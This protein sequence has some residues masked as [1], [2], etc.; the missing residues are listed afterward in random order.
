MWK[1]IALGT[2]VRL[3]FNVVLGKLGAVSVP[4]GLGGI[5]LICCILDAR[6]V[7]AESSLLA[8]SLQMIL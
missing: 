1:V 8:A 2:A 7:E 6:A 4:I 3:G 5:F